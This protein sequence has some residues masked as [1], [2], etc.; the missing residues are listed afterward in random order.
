MMWH[1]TLCHVGKR[2]TAIL[3]HQ[4]WEMGWWNTVSRCANIKS[5][6]RHSKVGT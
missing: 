5:R 4:L 1:D 3:V 2:V 6:E